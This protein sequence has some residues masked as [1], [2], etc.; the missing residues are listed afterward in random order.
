MQLIGELFPPTGTV[1]L[2]SYLNCCH[3]LFFKLPLII[4]LIL[5]KPYILFISKEI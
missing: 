2:P 5:K 4:C 1:L 3:L